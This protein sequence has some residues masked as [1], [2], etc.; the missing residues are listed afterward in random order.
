MAVYMEK[1]DG[2]I[3]DNPNIDF[4]RCDGTVFSYDE[5]NTSSMSNTSNALTITGGQG[6]Y[7]LAYIETDKAQEFTFASSLFTM[8]MFTMA[9]AVKAIEG[10]VGTQE[11]K[12]YEVGS[13]LKITLPFEVQA[14]SVKIRGLEEVEG[15]TTAADG[16]FAVKITA[17]SEQADGSTEITLSASDAT[18][19]DT[20][21]VSYR[22]RVIGAQ[23]VAVGKIRQ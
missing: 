17:S 16:K 14:G 22:R 21:R 23:R 6:N 13:G 11:T 8:D 5:V 18:A 1:Y 15:E 20:I 2:Y 3:A 19:G 12:R 9:N 10:D 7:P 4:E